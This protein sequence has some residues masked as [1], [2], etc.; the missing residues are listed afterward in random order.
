VIAVAKPFRHAVLG[1]A[2]EVA[3]GATAVAPMAAARGT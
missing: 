2:N 1:V 3:A